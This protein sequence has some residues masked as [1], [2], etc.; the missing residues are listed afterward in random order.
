MQSG[1]DL[2]ICIVHIPAGEHSRSGADVSAT[3]S[4]LANALRATSW[5]W[6]FVYRV[7]T[8]RRM[9]AI[10]D[11]VCGKQPRNSNVH[12]AWK[13]NESL[14]LHR[15]R[16]T[17]SESVRLTQNTWEL[18]TLNM[19]VTPLLSRLLYF[20][21]EAFGISIAACLICDFNTLQWDHSMPSWQ[22]NQPRLQ[23]TSTHTT[24]AQCYGAFDLSSPC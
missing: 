13:K 15:I 12:P 10:W 7:D 17:E 14:L 20:Q 19:C 2:Q 8:A 18:E 5:R 22:L 23:P 21:C 11:V 3:F 24:S 1:R 6:N 9:C 4:Q 16:E